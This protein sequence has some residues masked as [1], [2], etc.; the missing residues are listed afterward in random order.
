MATVKQRIRE[1]DVIELRETV[2]AWPA[3]TIGAV[4][5]ERGD[6]KLIEIADE[7]GQMLDLI[8][9]LEPRLKLIAKHSD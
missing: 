5:S 8:S 6:A 2:G 7:R 3:G 9:V 1:N 4:V